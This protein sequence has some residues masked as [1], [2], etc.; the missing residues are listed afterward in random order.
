MTFLGFDPA[1][2]WSVIEYVES[3]IFAK[4]PLLFKLGG[5]CE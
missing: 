1:A 4:V 2:K 5:E 3:K